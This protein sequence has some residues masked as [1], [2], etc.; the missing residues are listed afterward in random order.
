MARKQNNNW[1][2]PKTNWP[3]DDPLAPLLPT[4]SAGERR[5]TIAGIDDRT[6][7]ACHSPRHVISSYGT[8]LHCTRC[9]EDFKPGTVKAALRRRFGG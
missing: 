3:L 7:P 5:R 2:F 1:H 4:M 9:D 6:C 8:G